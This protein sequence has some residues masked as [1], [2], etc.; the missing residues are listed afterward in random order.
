VV[1]QKRKAWDGADE[2]KDIHM[3]DVYF[4]AMKNVG[5]P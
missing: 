5:N 3:R 2:S 4:I 1:L